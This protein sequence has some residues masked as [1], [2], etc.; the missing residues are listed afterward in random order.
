MTKVLIINDENI[1]SDVNSY[2]LASNLHEIMSVNSAAEGIS[3]TRRWEPDV[4]IIDAG[5][6][7][8]DG[9]KVCRDIRG[10]SQ[11]PILVL[12][13]LSNPDLVVQALDEGADDFLSKPVREE[14]L[15]AHINKL[16]RR[17]KADMNNFLSNN[18]LNSHVSS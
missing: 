4:V 10:F 5:L 18:H 1:T 6:P 3:A 15:I 16:T 12:S 9:W 11:V 13:I 7:D 17:A 8:Q 2:I 14:V